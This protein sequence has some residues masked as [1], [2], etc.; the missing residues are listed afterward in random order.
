MAK[1]KFQDF[2]EFFEPI[3]LPYGEKEY[4]LPLVS[5]RLGSYLKLIAEQAAEV[6][7]V[8]QANQD[9]VDNAE[10]GEEPELQELPE[11][12]IELPDDLKDKQQHEMML[13]DELIE[14]MSS[15]GV[16]YTYMVHAGFTLYY[17]FVFGRKSALAYWNSGGDPKALSQSLA[18]DNI[19][20]KNTGEENT[21][22]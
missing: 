10:E 22:Q 3:V 5:A 15:D 4:T 8:A 16:P 7:K 18:G 17:D 21:T 20:T 13:G 1:T 2:S 9:L 14:E 11:L 6:V 19:F 12:E